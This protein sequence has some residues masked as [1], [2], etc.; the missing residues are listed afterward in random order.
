MKCVVYSLLLGLS[1]SG[2]L[3]AKVDEMELHYKQANIVKDGGSIVVEFT[4]NN[5]VP[6]SYLFRKDNRIF[7]AD[8]DEGWIAVGSPVDSKLELAALEREIAAHVEK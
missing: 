5:E 8:H 7:R 3:E 6:V 2:C 4:D 1:L